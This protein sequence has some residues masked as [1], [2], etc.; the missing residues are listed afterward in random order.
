METERGGESLAGR[1]T[2]GICGSVSTQQSVSDKA[3][4][5]QSVSNMCDNPTDLATYTLGRCSEYVVNGERV[6]FCE[7]IFNRKLTISKEGA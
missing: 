3:K 1:L 7:R 2:P 6:R 4:E 5:I